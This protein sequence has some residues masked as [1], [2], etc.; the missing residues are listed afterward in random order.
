MRPCAKVIHHVN[1]V[2]NGRH[3]TA[4]DYHQHSEIRIHPLKQPIEGQHEENQDEPA[5]QFGKDTET[6]ETLMSCDVADRRS[7]VP[8][9]VQSVGNIDKE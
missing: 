1:E 2:D 5:D 7:R 4:E 9:H 8:F 3:H 6:E